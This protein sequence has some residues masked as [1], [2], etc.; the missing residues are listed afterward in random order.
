VARRRDSQQATETL[1][2]IEGVFDR[3]AD[4][5]MHNPTRVLGVLGGI[6]AV[7]AALG[8]YDWQRN[9][10]LDQ[11]AAA[12]AEV[13]SGYFRAMGA[14][15]GSFQVAE[16]ANPETGRQVREQYVER[17]LTVADEHSGT[18]PAVAARLEAGTLLEQAG[19]STGALDAWRRAVEAAGAGTTL[20]GVALVRLARGLERQGLWAEAAAAHAEA[21]AIESLPIRGFAL[22]DAARCYA[23][24]GDVAEALAVYA[25]LEELED[26]PPAPDHVRAR[27]EELRVSQAR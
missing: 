19:D 14:A 27:L 8:L 4:W 23:E 21:G 25:S 11:A 16:P 15:P 13:Q 1:Q 26:A 18:A 7:A 2:E 10:Q 6:L 20:R 24:A 5:V 17:F 22:G 9:R 12:V 3:L